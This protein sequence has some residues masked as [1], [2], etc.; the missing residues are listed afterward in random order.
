[1][2]KDAKELKW[3]IYKTKCGILAV[4]NPRQLKLL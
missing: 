2:D 3:Y 4:D 1:M